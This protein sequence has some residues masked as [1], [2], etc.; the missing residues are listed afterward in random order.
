MKCITRA[1][2]KE[3]ERTGPWIENAWVKF[4]PG[5]CLDCDQTYWIIGSFPTSIIDRKIDEPFDRR[6][7]EDDYT[8]CF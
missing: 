3:V 5:R 7:R 1:C 2:W 8:N 6:I 4:A